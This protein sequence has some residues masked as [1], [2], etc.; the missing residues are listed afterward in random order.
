MVESRYELLAKIASG[1]M[2]TVYVGRVRGAAGFWRL[3]AIKR[4]H[5]HLIQQP[6]FRAM[7]VA[8]ALLASRIHHTNVVSVLDVE[9]RD[10]ELLLAMDY[11]DGS[12]LSH[13][14]QE[15]RK[16]GQP[17]PAA[18]AVRVILDA[19]AGLQAAH[20]LTD[21]NGKPLGVVHRDVSPH[22]IL[23][24]TDGVARIA[25]FGI[26]KVLHHNVNA[27]ATGV[28]KGKLSYMAPEYVADQILDARSDVFG[29]GVVLWEQLAGKKLFRGKTDVETLSLIRTQA[30]PLV[31]ELRPSL[32]VW[33]DAPTARS[34]ERDRTR[35]YPSAGE[36]A[37]DLEQAARR[38][39]LSCSHADVAAFLK[40]CL[41]PELAERQALIRSCTKGERVEA[42]DE[43]TASMPEPQTAETATLSKET[44]TLLRAELDEVE[45][46][47][48]PLGQV[49]AVPDTL[50]VGSPAEA[51]QPSF[52]HSPAA[53]PARSR[54]PWVLGGL[55]AAGLATA[56]AVLGSSSSTPEPAAATA[57]SEPAAPSASAP[58]PAASSAPATVAET[59]PEAVASSAPA[60]AASSAPSLVVSAPPPPGPR[61]PAPPAPVNEKPKPA[62]STPSKPPVA[63]WSPP[64]NPYSK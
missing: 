20:E 51:T 63:G 14:T 45:P 50:P 52:A 23:I 17:V 35:R 11:V 34:L 38:A 62:P 21:E 47:P 24:G 13:L 36:F 43:V 61:P 2:A 49:S 3:V 48:T 22:N 41:G 4:A 32:G 6:G 15:A 25:D 54:L 31:S 44:T 7:L 28:L 27:T 8:E 58:A 64:D 59:A 30:V 37:S 56:L 53:A 57:A 5:P 46:P 60:P 1:G 9:E 26:A 12:S 42:H 55:G 16:N 19:C 39:G 18:I 33:F 29:M 40:D 10:G